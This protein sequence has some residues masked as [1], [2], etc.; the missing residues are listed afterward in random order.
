M[1]EKELKARLDNEATHWAAT[2]ERTRLE[3][4]DRKRRIARRTRNLEAL[5]WISA[6]MMVASVVSLFIISGAVMK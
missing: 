2:M 3:E 1:S 4:A 6:L 5:I